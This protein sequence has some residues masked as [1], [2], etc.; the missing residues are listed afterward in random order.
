MIGAT[1]LKKNKIIKLWIHIFTYSMV[2]F[3]VFIGLKIEPFSIKELIRHLFPITFRQWWFASTYFAFYLFSPYIN[4]LLRSFDKRDYQRFLILLTFCWCI[5]PTFLYVPWDSNELLWFAYLFSLAGYIRIYIDI[6]RVNGKKY[7]ILAVSLMLLR[8]LTVILFDVLGIKIPFFAAKATYF[9]H[10]QRIP[11]LLIALTLFVGFLKTNIGYKSLINIVSSATFGV[12]LIHDCYYVRPFLW[13]TVFKNSDYA[14]SIL[15]VPYSIIV[16]FVVFVICTTI[17]LIRIRY[18]EK[19][20]LGQIDSF[21][22]VVDKYIEK[23]FSLNIF[24]RM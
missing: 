3:C 8:F 1:G 21:S 11:T 2:S 6:D 23:F 17:E 5:I 9:Y 19:R 16:I 10:M 14:E 24:C 13:R 7:I 12:Y 18:L 20:Y 22:K 4:R 15:L